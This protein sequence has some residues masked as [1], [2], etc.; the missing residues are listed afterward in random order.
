[1]GFVKQEMNGCQTAFVLLDESESALLRVRGD[2]LNCHD[3]CL[4]KEAVFKVSC[5]FFSL[6]LWSKIDKCGTRCYMVNI[7]NKTLLCI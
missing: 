4:S 1:M 3:G 6:S 7:F 2:N 5:G